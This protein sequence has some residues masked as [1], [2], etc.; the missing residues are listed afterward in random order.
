LRVVL[1]LFRFGYFLSRFLLPTG[2]GERV[3]RRAAR[4]LSLALLLDVYSRGLLV[5]NNGDLFLGLM[6][7]LHV[8]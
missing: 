6:G 3:L 4:P 2:F 5:L 1:L 7:A 8:P